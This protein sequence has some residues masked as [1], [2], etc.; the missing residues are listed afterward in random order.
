MPLL[1]GRYLYSKKKT[2]HIYSNCLI[3]QDLTVI[4]KHANYNEFVLHSYFDDDTEADNAEYQPAPG[5]PGPDD[6]AKKD[7][8]SD[9]DDPLDAFMAGIE[10]LL[11]YWALN[12]GFNATLFLCLPELSCF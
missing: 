5:S 10:V 7:D 12:F 1:G 4:Y 11:T 9:S 2:F 8:D 6:S 3:Y